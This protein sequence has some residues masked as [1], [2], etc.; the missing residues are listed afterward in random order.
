MSTNPRQAHSDRRYR[1]ASR[2][3]TAIGRNDESVVV[4]CRSEQAR[5]RPPDQRRNRLRQAE[6]WFNPRAGRCRH[7]SPG[8]FYGINFP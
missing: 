3:Y 1:I 7:R 6:G 4:T 8:E 5:I 2:A